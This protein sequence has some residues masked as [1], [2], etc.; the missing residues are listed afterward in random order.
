ML[1]LLSS[2]RGLKRSA[3]VR[4]KKIPRQTV[5]FTLAR[6]YRAA[7]RRAVSLPGASQ[8]YA[9]SESAL[10]RHGTDDDEE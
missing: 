4:L 10:L 3:S 5:H 7:Q 2:K 6:K 8:C 9:S 1:I